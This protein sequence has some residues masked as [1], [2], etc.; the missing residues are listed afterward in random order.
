MVFGIRIINTCK[1]IV[2]L[3]IIIWGYFGESVQSDS[4]FR[5]NRLNSLWQKAQKVRILKV[6]LTFSVIR[7]YLSLKLFINMFI[8]A[9]TY[10]RNNFL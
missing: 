6:A 2:L 4:P 8:L 9:K 10:Y 5:I 1:I 7:I 3:N